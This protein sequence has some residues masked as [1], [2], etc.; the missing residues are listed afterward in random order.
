MDRSAVAPVCVRRSGSFAGA[1]TERL[2]A[3]VAKP[4]RFR[5]GERP[6]GM[7]DDLIERLDAGLPPRDAAEAHAREPYERLIMRIR[8]LEDPEPA[9]GWEERAVARWLATTRGRRTTPR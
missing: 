8:D 5:F 2:E 3:A 9:P 1:E 4:V 6:L 7:H